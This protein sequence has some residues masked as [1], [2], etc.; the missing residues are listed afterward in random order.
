LK[1]KRIGENKKPFKDFISRTE[2]AKLTAM[3]VSGGLLCRRVLFERIPSRRRRRWRRRLV[4]SVFVG[5]LKPW[6]LH[7]EM[8]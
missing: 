1:R 5:T 4:F 7:G 8:N 2:C 6:R 3:A